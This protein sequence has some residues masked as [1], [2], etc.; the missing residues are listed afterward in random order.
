MKELDYNY[1]RQFILRDAKIFQ[2]KRF[3]KIIQRF[4]RKYIKEKKIRA[5]NLIGRVVR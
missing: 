5:V 3:I 2:V 4:W 1:K